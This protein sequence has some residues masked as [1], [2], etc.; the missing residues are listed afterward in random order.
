[1]NCV[2]W[3]THLGKAL[4]SASSSSMST[5]FSLESRGISAYLAMKRLMGCTLSASVTPVW[6]HTAILDKGTRD[7]ARDYCRLTPA[8]TSKPNQ[9]ECI[10]DQNTANCGTYYYCITWHDFQPKTLLESQ[11]CPWACNN[12]PFKAVVKDITSMNTSRSVN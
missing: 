11:T 8:H 9:R 4:L 12:S 5:T 7:S 6:R 10:S 2:L 3:E 1:M